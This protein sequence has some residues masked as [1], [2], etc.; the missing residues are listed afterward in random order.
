M[1]P[2]REA[3]YRVIIIRDVGVGYEYYWEAETK[4]RLGLHNIFT[5]EGYSKSK[6]KALAA[7]K[8]FARINQIEKWELVDE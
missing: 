8:E 4:C 2:I 1:I 7:W 3:S 6:K 5:Q